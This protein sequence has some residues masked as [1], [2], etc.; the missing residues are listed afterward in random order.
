MIVQE[1]EMKKVND[2]LRETILEVAESFSVISGVRS[3]ISRSL[4]GTNSQTL[5][6]NWLNEK[7]KCDFGYKPI[8]K[9]ARSLGYKVKIVFIKEDDSETEK[10]IDETNSKFMEDAKHIL[11]NYLKRFIEEKEN[12][13]KKRILKPDIAG[14]IANMYDDLFMENDTYAKLVKSS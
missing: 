6:L 10:F 4:V 13:S 5:F 11:S 3:K 8:S 1:N 14:E 2:S 7:K 9:I 12:G